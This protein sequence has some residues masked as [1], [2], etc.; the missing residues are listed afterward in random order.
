MKKIFL[1]IVV[2]AAVTLSAKAQT[3]KGHIMV[4]SQFAN[5]HADKTEFSAIAS[6]GIAWF[7]SDNFALGATLGLGYAKP[8]SEDGTF[9]YGLSPM[10]RYYFAGNEKNKFFGQ[11]DFGFAGISTDGDNSTLWNAGAGLGYNHFINRSV[12]LELGAGYDY[13]KEKKI[14]G[15]SSFDLNFGIQVF[16]PTKKVKK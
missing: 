6:P 12:A 7:L 4:G 11:V 14:D 16:L 13:T 10:A 2:V 5:I 8:K 1:S 9:M 15:L 3:E